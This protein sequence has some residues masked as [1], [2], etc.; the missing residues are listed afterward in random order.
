MAMRLCD[1]AACA[2]RLSQDLE[3]SEAASP[4]AIERT[5]RAALRCENAG[6]CPETTYCVIACA[7]LLSRLDL[8]RPEQTAR[9][10]TAAPR[11]TPR[12]PRI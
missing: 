5:V 4:T 8:G 6:Q 7:G 10:V 9:P 12:Q 3:R 11:Q 2:L 1:S